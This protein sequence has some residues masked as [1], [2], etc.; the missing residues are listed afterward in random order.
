VKP[1]NPGP[2]QEI[3]TSSLALFDRREQDYVAVGQLSLPSMQEGERL[4]KISPDARQALC[5]QCHAPLVTKRIFSGDDRTP[6]GV[7]EGLSCMACHQGH[8]QKTRASCSTCHPQLSNCG[9]NVE[10]M[11]TTFK[12]VNSPHDVHTVK[13]IDCH[14]KGAP[15]SKTKMAYRGPGSNTFKNQPRMSADLRGSV[16]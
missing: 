10:M 9:L 15:K 7:H 6:V 3:S 12:S 16:R 2:I 11:D 5:Y 13:C 8:G 14:T 1:T 4:I